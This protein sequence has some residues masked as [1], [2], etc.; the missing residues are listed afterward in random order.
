MADDVWIKNE[1]KRSSLEGNETLKHTFRNATIKFGIIDSLPE[2]SKGF[3]IL[4]WRDVDRTRESDRTR[5]DDGDFSNRVFSPDADID[6]VKMFVLN[7]IK[8]FD[9]KHDISVFEMAKHLHSQ[10]MEL[11]EEV[12]N[13]NPQNL[14]DQS[15]KEA[16]YAG[17][18]QGCCE[19]LAAIGDNHALGK[20]LLF[21]TR[22]TK[23]M[24]RK[25]AYPET[26]KTL[27]QGIFAPQ[28]KLEQTHGRK[29]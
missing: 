3:D 27:E 16:G 2:G 17:Y 10:I 9:Q 24:A 8:H 26:Y 21:E 14:T 4:L 20:K 18:I 12:E 13:K 15:V 28:Q 7:T 1:A 6:T 22:V 5:I 23:D 11:H 25:Y 19:C 29:L